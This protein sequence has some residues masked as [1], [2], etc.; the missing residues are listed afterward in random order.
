MAAA[1]GALA[2]SEMGSI[3]VLTVKRMACDLGNLLRV[4]N[5]TL[6][7]RDSGGTG[8]AVARRATASGVE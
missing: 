8:G 6:S 5:S 1:V 7:Q 2:S 3:Y 4:W